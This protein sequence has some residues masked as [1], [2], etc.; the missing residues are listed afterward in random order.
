MIF[1]YRCQY[2]EFETRELKLKKEHD[3]FHHNLLA[4][5]TPVPSNMGATESSWNP[6]GPGEHRPSRKRHPKGSPVHKCVKIPVKTGS[7]FM[8]GRFL[9]AAVDREQTEEQIRMEEMQKRLSMR[10]TAQLQH[11][12]DHG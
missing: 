7:D 9:I 8:D 12:N 2:K 1:S 5:E 10:L 3:D 4:S 11:M 6:R